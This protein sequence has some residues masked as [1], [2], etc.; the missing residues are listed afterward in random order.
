MFSNQFSSK[1]PKTRDNKVS[2][3]RSQNERG[4]SSPRK[5]P[6]CGKCGKKHIGEFL[7]GTNNFFGL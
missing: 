7:V 5:K 1:F 6:T 3:S 2:N 4:T